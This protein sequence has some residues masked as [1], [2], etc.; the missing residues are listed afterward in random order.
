MPRKWIELYLDERL[1]LCLEFLK[2]V[3]SRPDLPVGKLR[4]EFARAHD[5][6]YHTARHIDEI[7]WF[8][9]FI[10]T[11]YRGIPPRPYR[12][13]T[14]EGRARVEEG[15][16]EFR[17]FKDAPEWVK[18]SLLWPPKPAPLVLRFDHGDFS[19]WVERDW[20]RK[21][22]VEGP[23]RF[24]RDWQAEFDP[25]YMRQRG[26]VVPR[27]TMLYS[28]KNR[29]VSMLDAMGVQEAARARR[30]YQL[31]G[32]RWVAMDDRAIAARAAYGVVPS[33]KRHFIIDPDGRVRVWRL[34]YL[35]PDRGRY[36]VDLTAIKS[37]PPRVNLV[38]GKIMLDERV[39]AG[40]AKF[41]SKVWE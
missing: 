12:E 39:P 26:A 34:P 29:A 22:Y 18:R 5:L 1:R 24:L 31:L 7:L 30:M 13:L 9:D 17:H 36:C 4:E 2:T 40:K 8:S 15:V 27:D 38:K 37:L 6:T 23:F 25:D 35:A 10:T 32:Y 14:P 28:V 21:V 19:F 3:G 41:V 33:R 11:V 20:G 16:L